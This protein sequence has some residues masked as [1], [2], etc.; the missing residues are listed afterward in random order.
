MAGMLTCGFP[1]PGTMEKW[2]SYSVVSAIN[3][4]YFAKLGMTFHF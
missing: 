4:K 3:K 1:S 2:G